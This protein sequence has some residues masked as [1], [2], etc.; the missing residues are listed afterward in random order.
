MNQKIQTL[1]ENVYEKNVQR[2]RDLHKYAETGWMEMRT[3]AIIAKALT[4]LGYEVLTGRQVCAEKGRLGVP[5]KE[6]L[7]QHAAELEVQGAPM[8]YV[9]DDMR[10]GYTGVIGILSCGPGP[11]VAIRFDIDGLGVDE[12]LDSSHRPRREGF[13]S[14]NPHMMHACG[15]DAHTAM[16]LGTAE[17]LMALKA[18]LHGTIKLL[19][20]P[21]EEGVRG[22]RA[23]V[24]KGHLDDV[25]Y[26]LGTHVEA[27]GGSND[28]QVMPGTY[29]SLATAKY[30]VT[31]EGAPA[32][33]GHEPE[34]GANA[35][36][37]AA[38]ASLNLAAIA[39]HGKGASR[40]N[41]GTLHAGTGRN[42]I[43]DHAKLELEVRGETT[44]ICRYMED[45]AK[46]VVRCAAD[47]YGCSCEMVLAGAADSH[48]SDRELSEQ[49]A[50][51]VKRD[52]PHLKVCSE[53]YDKNSGSEDISLMMSRVQDRGGK[54]SC[55]RSVTKFYGMPHTS[56]FDL[57]ETVI[58]DGIEVFSA[59]AY[60]LLKGGEG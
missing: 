22:A 59:L 31:Y 17:V 38:C 12:S 11:V 39:R 33:A 30:D 55:M 42:V 13:A 54:A 26:F 56:V 43:P 36:L 5:E 47:M 20:Q 52:L 28:G 32:H 27:E 40:I 53:I 58:L 24:L 23:M 41:V 25:D 15:H 18:E 14:V 29:G 46:R 37:A 2:R 6:R 57:D 4:E 7:L 1:A 50:R 45:A 34:Q 44:E 19:F 10:E 3:S 8:E 60:D 48:A 49:I 21:A 16:G 51:I 9:T 35:L